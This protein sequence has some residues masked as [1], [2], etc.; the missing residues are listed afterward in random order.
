MISTG[1]HVSNT[2]QPTLKPEPPLRPVDASS[3]DRFWRKVDKTA[4]CWIW[5]ARVTAHG[6]A[7]YTRGDK[8]VQAH[9][10]AWELAHGSVPAGVLRHAC[11]DLRCVRPEHMRLQEKRRGPTSLAKPP[12]ARLEA[13]VERSAGCWIWHGSR[14]GGGYGQFRD[15]D[16]RRER[17]GRM[18]PAHRFAWQLE[19][20]PIPPQFD[21]VHSC[22]NRHC[23]RPEHLRSLI[24]R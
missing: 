4:T 13:L 1:D 21:V 22:G 8:M 10:Y 19:N 15:Y 16:Q 11:W 20:G 9:R 6:N 5:T 7:Q 12:A 24:P 3:S 23:V 2:L 14:T 18:W 17:I